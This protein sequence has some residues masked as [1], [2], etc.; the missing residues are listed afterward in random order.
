MH[1][2]LF[3][4]GHPGLLEKSWGEIEAG[5]SVR[6]TLINL[7]IT[8]PQNIINDLEQLHTQVNALRNHPDFPRAAVIDPN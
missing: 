1:Y 5:C 2:F 7:I 4:S 8:D 6:Y 3:P